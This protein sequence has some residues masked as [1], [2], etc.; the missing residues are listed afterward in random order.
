MIDPRVICFI[1]A[2]ITG[3]ETWRSVLV[4]V[5]V[6]EVIIVV[7]IIEELNR[8]S[9]VQGIDAGRRGRRTVQYGTYQR[10]TL[11]MLL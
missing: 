9:R 3:I 11:M 8:V 7:I 4:I 1:M 10:P 6:V 5:V 2:I